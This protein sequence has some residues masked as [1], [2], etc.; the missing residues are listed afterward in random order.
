MAR[1][2]SVPYSVSPAHTTFVALTAA[3]LVA[4][5]AGQGLAAGPPAAPQK[6]REAARAADTASAEDPWAPAQAQNRPAAPTLDSPAELRAEATGPTTARLSWQPP[7]GAADVAGYQVFQQGTSTPILQ[8]AADTLSTEVGSLEPGISY[9]F[10]V[11]SVMADGRLSSTPQQVEL[12]MPP[13][14]DVTQPGADR[15]VGAPTDEG[16]PGGR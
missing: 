4:L 10:A 3:V 1:R 14:T 15:P 11:H 7:R 2:H 5:S 9:T 12:V 16:P 6:P 13:R 8:V